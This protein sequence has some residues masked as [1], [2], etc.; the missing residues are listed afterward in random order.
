VSEDRTTG[1]E[2]AVIGLAGRFPGADSVARFWENLRAG[3]ESIRLLSEEEL[4][5]SGLPA[6]TLERPDYVRLAGVIDGEDLFDAGLFGFTP[7]EA[8]ILDPQHRLFLECAW[9]ALED[10]GHD[11]RTWRR[12]IGVY[13]GAKLNTYL[14]NLYSNPDLLDAVGMFQAVVA[15]DKDFLA[16]RVSYKLDLTGPSVAVQTACSTSLAAVHLAC[17]GLL[18]GE[19]DLALAGGVSIGVPQRLGYFFTEGGI[20]SPDGHCRA[21]D[22][23]ARGTAAGHGLGI[24]VLKRLRDAVED[25]DRIYAVIKGSAMNNDGAAKV[26]YT[27]PSAEGQAKVIR[28]ALEVAEVDPGTVGYVEAHGTGTPLGDPIEV[29]ALTRAFR[30]RTARRGFCAIGSVKTNIGHLDTAAGIAGLIKAVLA[31]H[32]RELPPSLH[33]RAPNPEIDFASSP[34][35][36][37]DRLTPWEPADGPRRAG[38]SSFGIGGT[39]VHV[40]LEEAPEPERTGWARPWQLLVLS[41]RTPTA[42]EASAR[43]LADHLESHSGQELTDVAWTLQTGRR[44]L[45]HRRVLACRDRSEAIALLRE[46]DPERVFTRHQEPGD[47]SVAFLF[48]GQG[49]QHPGMA[50]E[51]YE[52]EPSFRRDLDWCAEILRPALGL[53]LR[54]VLFS[55]G[56]N[57]SDGLEATALAQPALFAVEWA[58]A[59]LWMSWGVRPS[60]LLGH[61]VGEYVAACLAGVF[62]LED[63]LRLVAARGRL[64]QAMLRGSMLAVWLPEE[65]A[66]AELGGEASVAAVNG[67]ESCVI[68]GPVETVEALRDRLEGRGVS[69]RRLYTSHAFHS[70]LM[71]PALRPFAQEMSGVRLSRPQMPFFSNLTGIL[72]RDDEATDPGYWVRHL[73]ETVRFG[74]SLEALWREPGRALLEVGP[75]RALRTLARQHPAYPPDGVALSSLPAPRGDGSGLSDFPFLLTTLGRLWMAGVEVDWAAFQEGGRRRKVSLPAYPFERRRH[76]VERRSLLAGPIAGV[77]VAETVETTPAVKVAEVSNRP[78]LETPYVAPRSEEERAVA[79]V[80][81]DLL[82]IDPIGVHDDFFE[83]GGGSLLATRLTARLRAVLGIDLS[84][85]ELLD[86]PTVAGVAGCA[87]SSVAGETAA[88][89][90]VSLVPDPENAGEPFPLTDVQQAYWIGRAGSLELGNVSTHYYLEMEVEG[91]DLERFQHALRRTIERQP[92]L[93]AVVL[94]EGLQRVL[95]EVPPY[96]IA[97]RDLRG[98]S[99]EEAEAGALEVR[100]RMSHQVLPSD[101]WPLF[102]V[103]ACLLSGGR[104]RL[105]L[106]FDFLLGDAWSLQLLLAELGRFYRD[107]GEAP[108]PL[109]IGFREYVLAEE[110]LRETALY[111]RSLAYWRERL[112]T[113]PPAPELPMA[114][115]PS[116]IDRP[117]FIRWQGR[118]EPAAWERLK[119]RA[120]RAGLTPSG[121]LLAAWSDVLAAWSAHPRFTLSLTLFNRLPLHPQVNDLIGDFTSV[122]LLEVDASGGDGFESRAR[123]LQRRLWEDLDHRYVS[124]VHVLRELARAQGQPGGATVP[125]VFT[126]LLGLDSTEGRAGSGENPWEGLSARQ[127]WAI[128][129]TPQVLLDHQADEAHGTMIFNWDVVDE[130]FP[131]EMIDAMLEAYV[132]LLR[133]LAVDEEAWSRPERELAAAAQLADR[134]AANATAVPVAERTLSSLFEE[135][136]ALQPDRPAVIAG[137]RSLD[138]AELDRRATALARRL[139]ELGARPNR[140]VAVVL[141]KGWEQV[142][143]VLAVVKAGAAYLPIDPGLPAER[144]RLLLTHGEVELALTIPRTEAGLDWP[145]GV[146]RLW[147]AEEP[148]GVPVEPLEPVAGPG[149]LAYVIFTSGSTG[150]PKGVMIDHRGAVNTILDVNER[151]GVGPAD[152]VLAVSALNFDLSVYDVFGLLAA[153]GAVVVPEPEAVRDPSRWP[154]RMRRDRVTIW[155]AVPALLEMLVEHASGRPDVVPESLRLV[156]LSG[157]W[158]PVALPGRLREL[159]PGAEVISLGGATEASIWSILHPV[160]PEDTARPSIPYGRPMRNQT[161]HVLDQDLEPR[162]VWVPGDLYIGGIGLA[163]GYWRDEERTRASFLVHPRTGERLYRTGDRGRYLPGGEIEFL[164]REDLQVKVHGHRI[165]LGEIEAALAQ[166]PAVE[167]CVVAAPG[168]RTSRRLVAWFV[169]RPGEVADGEDLARFLRSKLPAYM[170]PSAFVLIDRIP[171]TA[172]GKMDRRALPAPEAVPAALEAAEDARAPRTPMEE[173][174]CSLCAQVLR[175]ERVTGADSF[176]ELGGHSLLATRLLS[177]IRE[178]FG[179]ELPLRAVF[180]A[181]NVAS[182]AR[183]VERERRIGAGVEVP[184][185]VPAPRDR[186]LPLSFAQ[187]RLWFLKQLVPDS[188]LY[189]VHVAAR[190]LGRLDLEVLRRCFDEIVRRHEILRT[191][192]PAVQGRPVQVVTPPAPVPLPR[193]DLSALPEPRRRA[194]A[195]RLVEEEIQR[196][197]SFDEGPMVRFHVFRLAEREHV[198]LFASH[199]ILWDDWSQGVLLRELSALYRAFSAGRPSPLPEPPVQ[200]ADYAIWQRSWLESETLEEHLAYWSR[201]LEGVPPRLELPTDRPRPAQQTFRGRHRR[202]ELPA[203]LRDRLQELSRRREASLFMTLAAAFQT[204]LLRWSGQRDLV[205]GTLTGNRNRPEIEG[206]IG[207]FVNTMALRFDAAG[208]PT[209]EELLDRTRGVALEAYDHQDLPFERLIEIVKLPRDLGYTPLTQVVLNLFTAEKVEVEL[210]GLVLRWVPAEPGW[211]PFDLAWNVVPNDSGHLICETQYATDLYDA[212]TVD[213]M[214]GHFRILLEAA[215]ENPATRLS[216]LPLLTAE[217]SAQILGEWSGRT[218]EYPRDLS[219]DELFFRQAE[220]SPGAVALVFG[221]EETTYGDLARRADRL[222]RRLRRL[223][224]GSG[225]VVGILAE[226]SAEMV[227]G[228]IAILRAGGAYLPLDPHYPAERLS[229]MLEDAGVAL[230]LTHRGLDGRLPS[231]GVRRVDLDL[232]D[233]GDAAGNLPSGLSFPDSLAYVIYTSGSTGRPKGVS[234]PHRAVARLVLGTD[235]VPFDSDERVGQISNVSFDAATFEIWGALLNG[236]RLVGIPRETALNPRALA[237]ELTAQGITAMFLTVALFNQVAREVPRA[238]SGMRHLLVGGEAL[239]PRWIREVLASGPPRRLLNGYGPTENTTFSAWHLIEQVAEDA[240]TIPIG[241]AIANTRLYVVDVAFKPVPAGVP[242][243]LLLG[244]DGLATGYLGRPD[245][246]AAMFVPDPFGSEPGGRLYRTGDRVRFLTDGAVEFLGRFDHQVKVRGFRIELGEIETILGQHPDIRAAAVVVRED[247]GHKRLVGYVVPREGDIPS[248]LRSFLGERLPDYMVPRHFVSL[249]ALPLSYNGKVD[250]AALPAPEADV[251]APMEDVSPRGPLEETLAGIWRQVLRVE[252]VGARDNFFELGGDSILAIQVTARAHE[253]G[254]RITPTQIFQH[255]TLSELADVAETFVRQENGSGEV[256]ERAPLTPIQ[257]WFFDLDLEKPHH[258]NQSVLLEA[259]AGLD[260]AL[261]MDAAGRVFEHHDALRLRFERLGGQRLQIAGTSVAPIT[262]VGLDALPDHRRREALEATAAAVQA[263]LDLGV[264]PVSRFVLFEMGEGERCRLL[265]VV[266]HLVVDG[267]SW[268]ILLEDLQSAC[269][270]LAAGEAPSLP[271]STSF[272]RWAVLLAEHARSEAARSELGFWLGC[273]PG[274]ALPLDLLETD[275]PAPVGKVSLSLDAEETRALLQEVPAAYGTRIND[276]LLAALGRTLCRWTGRRRVLVDLE[277]HGREEELLHGVDLGRTVGWF[278]TL[279][280]VELEIDEEAGPGAALVAVKERLRAIPNRG[281]GFGLLRYLSG[282]PEIEESLRRLPAAEVSFNYLGQL[283]PVLPSGALFTPARESDGPARDSRARPAHRI[284][285]DG[286]VSGERLRLT[287]TYDTGSFRGGTIKGLAQDLLADLRSLIEH[288]RAP[289]AGGFTP[290]DFPGA[291]VSQEELDRIFAQ[292]GRS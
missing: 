141:E 85:R 186:D 161:F 52:A 237:T 213:R 269:R 168:E 226:P 115:R 236:A 116:E 20:L 208:D 78:G 181:A 250:R 222:A 178:A 128:S 248:D 290:S 7:R 64:M 40:V 56:S 79:R 6:S 132:G 29:E 180:E 130:I 207:F 49:S 258:F 166:H 91:L 55:R 121:V 33:F 75:G 155:N 254:L 163:L 144:F 223:G 266:H 228:L 104:V 41:A 206:L 260:P 217:E 200:Y 131:P 125:V 92:M 118:L 61:S 191:L 202:A 167:A 214:L 53:D 271:R 170:V 97:V 102:E 282:D 165:E 261:L 233:E 156:L 249:D 14:L 68:A 241:K 279:F 13:A 88:P 112:S 9:E 175:R 143:A 151:F 169:L 246:T 62:S 262:R 82:G 126:S 211:A 232:A 281:I 76:W 100:R 22:A 145:E 265:V 270:Q 107:G 197:F 59:R 201:R 46:P 42:L 195:D 259:D 160:V 67:P 182:L 164:G 35:R 171:L 227:A 65:E 72:I 150:L 225:D 93:R 198:V 220:R 242:G 287:W 291:P 124:G 134:E 87:A 278:T 247:D 146:R 47:R 289:E 2:I 274:A 89:L 235:Y 239:E 11:P 60:V 136:A 218:A 86:H 120:A 94:P 284:E 229:F 179:V 190:A 101:R 26:G 3:V 187:Q 257:R 28:A 4:T 111:E 45:E 188:P 176:F 51:V 122:V 267:V 219:L 286:S 10:S 174:L 135:K 277:G 15:N 273:G 77:G 48:P 30:E 244:G 80:W 252:R 5:A 240:W 209:F 32:H 12:P 117:R 95:P 73:R 39:N 58:L 1:L 205:I 243:E 140:L 8:D 109:E 173:I 83:L 106:S 283:D 285:I 159:V 238:F 98:V 212:G 50:A 230:L 137:D 27:A 215:A 162:P 189:N 276:A 192:L 43:R 264:G 119:A 224:A 256:V 17:Q 275:E 71:E 113:L 234:V 147:V 38:V 19:C 105:H 251:P 31:L 84:L 196:P 292:L 25:G 280:P 203:E 152:R 114:R 153:G 110:R 231:S 129:Q 149:D 157:D 199:H 268:R 44:R 69:C 216:D 21:F 70:F 81:S 255:H 74:A 288:C 253:A 177:R 90:P 210:P 63:A 184:P 194:E 221:G 142:V 148:P 183:A 158:I 37:S 172:N 24:V 54:E 263:S 127:V 96:E 57:G 103:A 204:L 108:A 18:G 99:D 139:R 272:A 34:F 138:Y 36:V 154:E 245:A 123:R 16:T 193:I 185:I 23:D 133:R 66:M